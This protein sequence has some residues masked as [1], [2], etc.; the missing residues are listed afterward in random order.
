MKTFCILEQG[1]FVNEP[2]TLK[3]KKLFTTDFSDFYRLNWRTEK[4]K[5]AFWIQK[6]ITWSEGRSILFEKVPKNYD[7]YI[8]IDD[9]VDFFTD[10]GVNIP[11]KIKELLIKYQPIAGTLYDPT[12]WCFQTGIERERDLAKKCFPIAGYDAQVQIFSK[13]FADVMFPAIHHGSAQAFGYTCWACYR[14]YPSKQ[15]CFTDIR[16]KNTRHMR[17][18]GVDKQYVTYNGPKKIVELFKSHVKDNSFFSDRDEI[19]KLNASL[20]EQPVDEQKIDFT[21]EDLAKIYDINNNYFRNRKAKIE[22]S[23]VELLLRKLS[24]KL[25]NN[26]ITR[27]LKQLN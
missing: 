24:R 19:I 27:K 15:I 10:D 2:L 23:K 14:L 21:L 5:N 7:Y 16:V 20:F 22:Y 8:L 25:S 4:D 17:E 13:S 1:E 26:R 18:A 6:N 11:L 3:H 9:D 12:R